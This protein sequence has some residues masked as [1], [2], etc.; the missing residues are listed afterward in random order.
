MPTLIMGPHSASSE[1]V[2]YHTA[3][4][5]PAYSVITAL[6]VLNE[7]ITIIQ[8]PAYSA[9]SRCLHE[10]PVGLANICIVDELSFPVPHYFIIISCMHDYSLHFLY[11]SHAR[12]M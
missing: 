8:T 10:G 3:K 7:V 1:F 2:N 9:V 4:Y 12:V 5:A 6:R 11:S